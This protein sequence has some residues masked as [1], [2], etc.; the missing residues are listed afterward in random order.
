MKNLVFIAIAIFFSLSFIS[1]VP[2]VLEPV[3]IETVDTSMYFYGDYSNYLL[4]LA[5]GDKYEILK[6]SDNFSG[7]KPEHISRISEEY[8][9]IP[10]QVHLAKL[11][12]EFL[13]INLQNENL[14]VPEIRYSKDLEAIIAIDGNYG[15]KG[16]LS[17]F[18]LKTGDIMKTE[19]DSIRAKEKIIIGG[20]SG[21]E[22]LDYKIFFYLKS[23]DSS[24]PTGKYCIRKF[25]KFECID[26]NGY[27]V[28]SDSLG[29]T[30]LKEDLRS[31]SLALI[32]R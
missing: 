28:I 1:C 23:L 9:S 16:K 6:I 2:E 19:V 8:L 21:I 29:N 30:S 32:I 25:G 26:Y 11:P 17:I 10:G 20:G 15:E 4:V 5:I 12:K 7:I 27:V 18:D 22:I 14:I 3:E 31:L 13:K 24:F